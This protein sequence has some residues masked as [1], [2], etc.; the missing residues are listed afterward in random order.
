MVDSVV[1]LEAPPAEAP[2]NEAA[3]KKPFPYHLIILFALTCFAGF[4]RFAW[5]TIL[6]R[7]EDRR[8][9]RA[10]IPIW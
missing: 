3:P 4:I 2:T 9:R 10:F 6:L 1:Q 8:Q 5:T 7:D